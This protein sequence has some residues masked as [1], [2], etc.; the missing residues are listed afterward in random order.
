MD[1]EKERSFLR[2]Q[3]LKQKTKIY[4]RWTSEDQAFGLE[5]S[6]KRGKESFRY[7]EIKSLR[8]DAYLIPKRNEYTYFRDEGSSEDE[9][10]CST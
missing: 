8:N 1:S 10:R 3:F 6:V 5:E 7:V 4:D 9:H 2:K